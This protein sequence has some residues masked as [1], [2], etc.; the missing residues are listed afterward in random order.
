MLNKL[1]RIQSKLI[2]PKGQYNSFG[3]YNYRSCEDILEA[4]K[5]L[6]EEVK[7]TI[8]IKDEIEL[9]GTRFY[10]KATATLYDAESKESISS[11][12]YAREE[13]TKKGMDGSQVTGAA[14]SYARKYA[15]NGLFAIDDVKDSDTDH[16]RPSNLPSKP[17][18]PQTNNPNPEKPKQVVEAAKN[19]AKSVC[20][21]CGAEI[22]SEKVANYSKDKFG[23]VLCFN[24]QKKEPKTELK[25]IEDDGLPF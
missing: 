13:E 10:V 20:E 25:P 18:K 23:K 1:L 15:L 24:C 12:A 9:I 16:D 19:E 17:Q 6:L 8:I 11:T 4:L 22:K 5:P 2:A 14:S 3:G 21:D 7:A